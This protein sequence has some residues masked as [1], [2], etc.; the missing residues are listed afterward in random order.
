MAQR[1]LALI[2]ASA[3]M[4][5]TFALA[6]P[7]DPKAQA[8]VDRGLEISKTKPNSDEEAA[9]YETAVQIDPRYASAWFNLG[10]VYLEQS[11]NTNPGHAAVLRDKAAKC[12][13]TCAELDPKRVEARYNAYLALSSLKTEQGA[14]A[15]PERTARDLRQYLESA[16]QAKNHDALQKALGELEREIANLKRAEVL[17]FTP[18]KTIVAKLAAP[19]QRGASPYQGGR[20]PLRVLF[21]HDSAEIRSDQA[22]Q[23]NEIA[24]ALK[25]PSLQG[26]QIRVEGHTD[27][28]GDA[29]YNQA[30]SERRAQAIVERLARQGGIERS[31]LAAKGYGESRAIRPNDTPENKQVNRRVELVN[32][33]KEASAVSE[34]RRS[35][36]DPVMDSLW[37]FDPSAGGGER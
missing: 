24:S 19:V 12:F 5:A 17:D 35:A 4:A 6:A 27:S 28:D 18:A 22:P 16:P 1:T 36:G 8:E 25:D 26:A 15:Q 37:T 23:L 2:A 34:I 33:T 20:V 31:R 13:E 7:P 3:C 21:D 11:K 10:F 30:L 9:C 14:H 29:L 32:V